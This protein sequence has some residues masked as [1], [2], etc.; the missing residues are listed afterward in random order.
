MENCSDIFKAR[1]LARYTPGM[2]EEE[3]IQIAIKK[4]LDRKKQ[5]QLEAGNISTLLFVKEKYEKQMG[6]QIAQAVK[7]NVQ[8]HLASTAGQYIRKAI[9]VSLNTIQ[10]TYTVQIISRPTGLKF[11]A[12]GQ[13]RCN[14]Y[15]GLDTSAATCAVKP[16]VT[17]AV[18]RTSIIFSD[19]SSEST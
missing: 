11:Q 17:R 8:P 6:A 5:G 12:D 9:S 14:H 13:Q 7:V 4:Y 2:A 1:H 10:G 3:C 15:D 18:A 16:I 19:S